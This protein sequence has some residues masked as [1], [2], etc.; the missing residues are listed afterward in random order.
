[1]W[2]EICFYIPKEFQNNPP[3]PI[4]KDVTIKKKGGEF[5]NM[6]RGSYKYH[7]YKY[8]VDE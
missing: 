1:M 4:G 8:T 7:S 5:K 6:T 3:E 2:K